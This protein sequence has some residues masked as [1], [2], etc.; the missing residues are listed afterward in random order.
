LTITNR[1]LTG[2]LIGITGAALGIIGYVAIFNLAYT[3]LIRAALS[4]SG[5]L[6]AT[7]VSYIMPVMTGISVIAGILWCLSAYGFLTSKSWAWTSG[8]VASTMS[9][10]ADF[11]PGIPFLNFIKTLPPM[12][13]L[14]LVNLGF[15]LTLSLYVAGIN[16][17]LVALSLLAGVSFILS[18]INGVA[19]THSLLA[20]HASILAVT[21]PLSFATSI[22]WGALVLFFLVPRTWTWIAGVGTCVLGIVA[23]IPTAV[24]SNLQLER[25]SLF[26]PAPILATAVILVLLLPRTRSL[27]TS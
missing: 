21:I 6:E 18:F 5:P 4:E 24:W 8:L 1:N 17:R 3:S 19:A 16:K 22:A 15:F 11:F 25:P 7:V 26:W 27:L 12:W 20:T 2:V 9:I 23:G 14:F 10:L 13:L